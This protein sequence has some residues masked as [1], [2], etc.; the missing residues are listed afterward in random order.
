MAGTGM[1][2]TGINLAVLFCIVLDHFNF[3][4][5]PGGCVMTSSLHVCR[6]GS[7]VFHVFRARLLW[8]KK[9]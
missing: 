5:N 9:A 7:N 2:G 8:R 1:A 6:E 3:R 4:T